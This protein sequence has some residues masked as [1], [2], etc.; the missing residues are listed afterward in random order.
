[1]PPA[2]LRIARC[3]GLRRLPRKQGRLRGLDPAPRGLHRH[4][5]SSPRLCLRS[6]SRRHQRLDRRPTRNLTRIPATTSAADHSGTADLRVKDNS[7][8]IETERVNA[9]LRQ[10]RAPSLAANWVSHGTNRLASGVISF[11]GPVADD[12][13]SPR[14]HV[15]AAAP[16]RLPPGREPRRRRHLPPEPA[17]QRV[18]SPFR[19]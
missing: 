10:L 17:E 3:V 1:M 6:L 12:R 15:S 11:A 8:A 13:F 14:S 2:L 9:D 5:R 4:P 19:R 16:H 18:D 7:N